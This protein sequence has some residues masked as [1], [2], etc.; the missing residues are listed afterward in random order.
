MFKTFL[1]YQIIRPQTKFQGY[2]GIILVCSSVRLSVQIRV[3]SVT[4]ICFD[5]VNHIRH[6][7]VLQWY[8]VPRTFMT[9]V[10]L[11]SLTLTS[12]LLAFFTLLH[13]RPVTPVYVDISIS[14]LPYGPFNMWPRVACIHDPGT[15]LTFD[16]KVTFLA[17]SGYS[18]FA[19]WHTCTMPYLAHEYRCITVGRSVTWTKMFLFYFHQIIVQF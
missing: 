5:I 15:T 10:R 13:V 6:I 2:I 1:Q 19:L 12:N 4:F 11:V 8:D 9:S 7:G 3:L 17:C 18:C 14:F 16:L